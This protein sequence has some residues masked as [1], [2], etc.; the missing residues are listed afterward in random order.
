MSLIEPVFIGIDPTSS[1]SAFTYAV[2]DRDLRVVTL[3]EG[4][5]KDLVSILEARPSVMIAVNAPANVNRGLVGKKMKKEA[6]A[7]HQVRGAQMRMA[8]YELRQYGIVVSGTP[9]TV[10]SCPAWI[11]LGFTLHRELEKIGFVKYPGEN[12]PNQVLETHPH[13]SYCVLTETVPQ[14]KP[15]LEGRL[16]RQLT[17][18][19][20]GVRIQ[21]P[22]DFFEE[23]TRHKMVKGLW[24]LELLYLP[25]QLDALVSAYTA[26]LVFNKPEQT[27]SVGDAKEGKIF[28]P[29]NQLKEKY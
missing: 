25:E 24:P 26:W 28:L 7:G 3:A 15:S 23:I 14:P 2:L 21:D 16:Q 12:S 8:E 27:S 11:Q 13:A 29:K 17:L 22:M 6:A 9:A 19:E 5:L 18:Y 4:E 20:Q 10:D 1:R